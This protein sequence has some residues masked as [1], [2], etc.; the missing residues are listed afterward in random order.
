MAGDWKTVQRRKLHENYLFSLWEDDV[1]RPDGSPGKY[2]YLLKGPGVVIIPFDGEKIYL[3]NQ[4]RYTF[5]KRMWELPAGKAESTDFLQEARKELAE[6][7]GFS[8]NKWT[9]LGQFACGPGHT[10]HL[11]KIF[12]AEG[13]VAG[14]A[15]R[16]GG[17]ADMEV[18]AFTLAE[19]ESM[20]ERGEIIDSWAIAPLYF[21]KRH[22]AKKA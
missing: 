4:F 2:Y 17:E 10:N 9:Y 3:V 12:L 6:E 1:L 13:L 22:L 5:Q 21:F 7:T 19:I 14:E 8:A 16:E 20:I 11:G 15:K 18:C